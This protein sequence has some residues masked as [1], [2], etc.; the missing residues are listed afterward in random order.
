[1]T[2]LLAAVAAFMLYEG[3]APSA[4]A[5]VKDELAVLAA[6]DLCAGGACESVV[7][8]GADLASAACQANAAD[9]MLRNVIGLLET[10]SPVSAADAQTALGAAFATVDQRLASLPDPASSDSRQA[11]L[12]RARVDQ[13]LLGERARA[14]RS[15][16]AAQVAWRRAACEWA[17]QNATFIAAYTDA[18]GFGVLLDD[19][20][21]VRSAAQVLIQHSEDAALADKAIT[22]LEA[23]M[24]EGRALNDEAA[25]VIDR[26]RIRTSG[27]QLYGTHFT[28]AEGRAV[29]R[30]E[31]A[32]RE[33]A[34]QERRRRGM[35]SL[36]EHQ[37][38]LDETCAPG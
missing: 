30:P 1:M 19:A 16:W 14:G 23:A 17:R 26:R 21:E 15:D 6:G 32:D 9:A 34:D 12:Y 13:V 29:F 24:A 35:S 3:S 27:R 4:K 38:D 18:S 25:A 11:L 5:L 36:A 22:W 7:G 20:Q 28:C 33:A 8:P 10:Q 37:R 31:L 2:V